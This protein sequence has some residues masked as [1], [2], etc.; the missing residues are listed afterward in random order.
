MNA[1]LDTLDVLGCRQLVGDPGDLH[2]DVDRVGRPDATR[3][4]I[5]CDGADVVAAESSARQSHQRHV[6]GAGMPVG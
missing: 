2:P 4:E 1:T 3:D 5:A 6:T